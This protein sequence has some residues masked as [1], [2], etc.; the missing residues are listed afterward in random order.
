MRIAASHIKPVNRAYNNIGISSRP[1]LFSCNGRIVG[2]DCAQN[3][4]LPAISPINYQ[5]NQFSRHFCYVLSVKL[6]FLWV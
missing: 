4:Y 1:H 2:T 6:V 3:N 5:K